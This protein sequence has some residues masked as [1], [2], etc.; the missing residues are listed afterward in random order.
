MG[1]QTWIVVPN[2]PATAVRLTVSQGVSITP[3]AWSYLL[4]TFTL[5]YAVRASLSVS[6]G[7]SPRDRRA[8]AEPAPPPVMGDDEGAAVVRLLMA[9]AQTIGKELTSGLQ[10]LWFGL[11]GV[12]FLGF[13][14][15]EGSISASAC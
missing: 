2:P 6:S 10:E 7:T 9:I 13:F 14:I 15:L 1:R 8:Y 5:V 11:I 4:V 3:A 12:L